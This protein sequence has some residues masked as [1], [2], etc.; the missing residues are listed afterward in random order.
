MQF[1]ILKYKTYFSLNSKAGV[2]SHVTPSLISQ[3]I[4]VKIQIIHSTQH[5]LA[6]VQVAKKQAHGSSTEIRCG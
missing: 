2:L 1:V 5:S 4:G 3:E 6:K